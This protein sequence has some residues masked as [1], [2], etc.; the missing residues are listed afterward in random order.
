M[1]NYDYGREVKY[2]ILKESSIDISLIEDF[3]CGNEQI[4]IEI[5][6]RIINGISEYVVDT[7]SNKL[8]AYI[9]YEASGLFL[10]H[11]KEQITKSALKINLFALDE[12][13]QHLVYDEYDED[14]KLSDKV[15]CDFLKRFRDISDNTLFFEYIILYS[16]PK[17]V[18]FYQRNGF[19]SFVEYMDKEKYRFLDG[20]TPMYIEI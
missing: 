7:E 20:C 8:I 14:F 2:D 4:D 3:S 1:L 18:S 15:F 19:K 10:K 5:K 17:A 13:Y 16:V 6:N 9:N 12:E 11:Q